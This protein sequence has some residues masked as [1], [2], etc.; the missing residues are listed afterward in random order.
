MKNVHL[1]QVGE[2]SNKLTPE[3]Q[4]LISEFKLEDFITL[5]D[6]QPSASDFLEQF[7]LYVMSSERE[8]LPLTIFEAFLKKT[9][10]VSTKA[11]GIP[12]A[13][14]HDFNGYL[15]EVR[16]F[17]SLASNIEELLGNQRKR[18]EFVKRSY[19]IFFENFT[20]GHTAMNT[21]SIYQN[22]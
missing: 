4:N 20:A 11:G 7:D 18:E 3:I 16:D 9:P 2:F 21:L 14:T 5:T 22:I 19:D 6:F 1:L 13:I 8:G 15:S 12:E 10:V 17:E